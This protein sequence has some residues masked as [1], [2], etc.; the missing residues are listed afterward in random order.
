MDYSKAFHLVAK[1]SKKSGVPCILI[2]GFAV[3]FHKV[4]RNTLDVDFLTTKDDFNKIEAAL[5][6][7]GYSED[8]AGDVTVRM[9]NKKEGLDI[10]FMIVDAATRA[11]ILKDGIETEVVS[12][13]LVVP[14]VEH[15]I[16]LKLHAIK[17]NPKNRMWKDLPDIIKLIKANKIDYESE[18][19]RGNCMKF[20]SGDIY[21]KIC[22]LM[23]GDL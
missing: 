12:E 19:F 4:S 7:S 14:S 2:G 1:A 11:K 21:G 3:N 18:P 20:G 5:A 22:G 13:K 17:C 9:S 10:D 15:L 16:A 23:S 6:D 8:F